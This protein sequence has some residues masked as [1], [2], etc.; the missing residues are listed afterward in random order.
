MT[1]GAGAGAAWYLAAA[2]FTLALVPCAA[3]A[4]LG[5]VADRLIALELAGVLESMLLFVLAGATGRGFLVDLGLVLSLSSFGG[6]LV[7]AR[8][9]ERSV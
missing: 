6:G 3:V 9:L 5:T 8:F 1:A 4:L 2:L 7:F